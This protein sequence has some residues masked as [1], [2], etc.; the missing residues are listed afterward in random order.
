MLRVA[1]TVVTA[2]IDHHERV[3]KA[4]AGHGAGELGGSV[5]PARGG[6]P[7]SVIGDIPLATVCAG[8]VLSTWFA[9]TRRIGRQAPHTP[10]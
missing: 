10:A 4:L 3:V 1:N 9:I 2:H 5:Q 7:Y 6:T 8:I